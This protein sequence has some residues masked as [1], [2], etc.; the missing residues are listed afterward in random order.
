MGPIETLS[1]SGSGPW[2]DPRSV[3]ED[4]PAVRP[5]DAAYL[6]DTLRPWIED[7]AERMQCCIDFLAAGTM[8]ALGSLVGRKVGI[9]PKRLDDW[10]E[11]PDLWGCLVGRPGVLKSPALA[12]GLRPLQGL[13]AEAFERHREDIHHYRAQ[14]LVEA[15]ELKVAEKVIAASLQTGDRDSAY[16][17]AL[18]AVG[19]AGAAPAPRRYD[20]NDCTIEKLGELLAANPNGL[21]V[22]RDELVG[23]LRS[24]DKEGYEEA[25]AFYLEAWNG[26]GTFT[27]DRI[28]RGTVRIPSNTVSIIG[29]IQPALLQRY[30]REA[31]RGGRGA[32]GLIQRFQVA[33]WPDV[34][35]EWRNVDRAPNSNARSEAYC[36]FQHLDKLSAAAVGAEGGDGIPFLHFVPDAQDAFDEWLA[37]LE[38]TIRSGDEHPAYEAHLAKYRKLVPALALILHLANRGTGPLTLG[39]L[40][41]ALAWSDYLR[42]T[43]GGSIRPYCAPTLRPPANWRSTCGAE[44][45]RR[46]SACAR[47]NEN[48]GRVWTR[49]RTSSWRRRCFASWAG[50]A[51]PRLTAGRP[52]DRRDRPSRSTRKCLRARWACRR[53]RHDEYG[54]PGGFWQFCQSHRSQSGG[55]SRHE[56]RSR[57]LGGPRGLQ[58]RRARCPRRKGS[59]PMH[60]WVGGPA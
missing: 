42:P 23:F 39:S 11:V 48:A 29:C 21:L 58:L 43:R 37:D 51:K 49:R 26:T 59:T 24:L 57:S 32:D 45:W 56:A 14:Q 33:V 4:L 30:V 3:P 7:N 54:T 36:V 44:P 27:V 35:R 2:L 31:V 55:N 1:S 50:F 40:E 53:G 60:P 13:A 18:S 19:K 25:R 34:P 52:G 22:H 15:H 6:P 10:I 17:A 46:P 41:K 16:A 12:Q 28:G 38:M 47:C 9:R 8:V 20:T 5:F